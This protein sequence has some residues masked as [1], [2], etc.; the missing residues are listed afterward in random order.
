[1][2]SKHSFLFK[3]YLKQLIVGK[4][5]INKTGAKKGDSVL[6]TFGNN[7]CYLCT[8]NM[9]LSFLEA[10]SK[11][12]TQLVAWFSLAEKQNPIFSEKK[13]FPYAKF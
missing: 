8:L 2:F 1:M 10:Q 12:K 9:V 11:K 6:K 3:K 5:K 7:S 13:K 4:K